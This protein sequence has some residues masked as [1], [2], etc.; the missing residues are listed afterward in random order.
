M[1]TLTGGAERHRF[2]TDD[3][4][5]FDGRDTIGTISFLPAGCGRD[6]TLSNVAW[7]WGAVAIDA[8]SFRGT[9]DLLARIPPFTVA[10]D[11][12]IASLVAQMDQVLKADGALDPTWCDAVVIVLTDHLLRMSRQVIRGQSC[13]YRLTDWQMR[14]V[15]ERMEAGLTEHIRIAELAAELNMSEGHFYRAFRATSGRTPLEVITD[16]R[17]ERA[18][19]LLSTSNASLT[20]IAFDVG[21]TSP[22]Y[23]ARAFRKRRGMSPSEW[24]GQTRSNQA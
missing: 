4:N 24:R 10:R 20:E 16:R 3:G 17:V 15:T 5:I 21:F 11:P 19:R 13:Q 12:L 7:S 6:L 23:L 2:R 18:A 8:D 1:A 22:S 9:D 14:R